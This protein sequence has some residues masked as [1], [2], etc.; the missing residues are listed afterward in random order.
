[1]ACCDVC[2]TFVHEEDYYEEY[3]MYVCPDCLSA[4]EEELMWFDE[5]G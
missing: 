4:L 5:Q 2:R 1:M 3:D